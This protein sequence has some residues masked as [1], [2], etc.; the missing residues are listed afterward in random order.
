MLGGIGEKELVPWL[1]VYGFICVLL[2][3][4]ILQTREKVNDAVLSTRLC[5]F[6]LVSAFNNS[7]DNCVCFFSFHFVLFMAVGCSRRLCSVYPTIFFF[8]NL[9]E[10]IAYIIIYLGTVFDLIWW[11]GKDC[12]FEQL[13]KSCSGKNNIQVPFR[14]SFFF[15][16]YYFFNS[17]DILIRIMIKD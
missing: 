3:Y 16:S 14:N 5:P 17:T 8:Y 9:T 7:H 2:Y 15:S 13:Q 6:V 12:Q 1:L 10:K 4:K 11:F